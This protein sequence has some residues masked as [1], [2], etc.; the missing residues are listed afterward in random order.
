[1]RLNQTQKKIFVAGI[2]LVLLSCMF[3]PW[4]HT[5]SN[6]GSYSERPAGYALILK[7]PEKLSNHFAYGVKLDV[8]RL[9]IQLLIV[10]VSA[11]AGIML[12]KET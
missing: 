6:E 11:G 7:P 2:L 1:M 12:T 4:M 10:S 5:I 8:S 3:P 9:L